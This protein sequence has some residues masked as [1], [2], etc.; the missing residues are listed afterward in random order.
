MVCMVCVSQP[1]S[2]ASDS[3]D[4]V[5]SSSEEEDDGLPISRPQVT[6]YLHVRPFKPRTRRKA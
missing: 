3:D 5:I 4:L 6:G 1:S 2:A